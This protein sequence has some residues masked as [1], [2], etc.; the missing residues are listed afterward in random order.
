MRKLF[1]M[2]LAISL[3]MSLGA[4][5]AL[6]AK[7]GGKGSGKPCPPSSPVGKARGPMN[8]GAPNCGK[9]KGGKDGDGKVCPPDSPNAGKPPPCGKPGDGDGGGPKPPEG[10]CASADL[11]V[12]R[13]A[14]IVCVYLSEG[15]L[16]TKEKECPDALIATGDIL[17]TGIGACVFLPPDGDTPALPRG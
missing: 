5:S 12:L 16:A 17:D 4:G 11:V 7:D 15:E 2:A 1:L 3:F 10:N 6:A 14:K 9:G 8:P 13:G